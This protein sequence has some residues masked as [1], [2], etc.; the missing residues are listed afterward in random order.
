[1]VRARV[2]ASG[3]LMVAS[4]TFWLKE[5][6]VEDISEKYVMKSSLLRDLKIAY[7]LV[8][9]YVSCTQRLWNVVKGPYKF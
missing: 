8:S 4:L 2:T 7:T 6:I 5:V 9:V 3:L 1:M